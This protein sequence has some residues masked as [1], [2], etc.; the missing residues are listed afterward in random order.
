[1]MGTSRRQA[2]IYAE[3]LLDK[4]SGAVPIEFRHRKSGLTLLHNGHMLTKCYPSK[5]GMFA[6]DCVALALGIPFPKLGESA[7]TSVTTGILFRAISISNLDVR[8]P[9]A[10]ILLER[11]LSEAAD[12]RIASTT[13][14]D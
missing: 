8:I 5:I 14:G 7:Y 11:L 2:W 1:M 9:E 13:S 6:A 4:P 12:Q 10:R 3:K